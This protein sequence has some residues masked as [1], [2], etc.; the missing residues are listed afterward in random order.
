MQLQEGITST[1][2]KIFVG[3]CTEDMT[4]DDLR[5]FFAN[6]GEVLDVYIPR[7]FRSFAFVT[8][9]DH[10]VAQSLCGEEFLIKG[11]T[12]HVSS[13]TPKPGA[14]AGGAFAAAAARGVS[15]TRPGF[16]IPSIVGVRGNIGMA[17]A[18]VAAKPNM[19]PNMATFSDAVITAAQSA[20][21]QQGW[22]TI[23]DAMNPQAN[24]YTPT[25]Y[26]A[27]MPG[28]PQYQ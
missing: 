20:L 12:V 19:L 5:S 2:R 22:G 26:G 28:G 9:A 11:H 27:P 3:R 6:Y 1:G 17:N 23:L 18:G 16:G 21:A 7:P 25:S 8:F 14:G 13:A 24:K 10:L 15:S 4:T